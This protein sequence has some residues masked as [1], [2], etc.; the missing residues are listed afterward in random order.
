MRRLIALF[1]TT[2]CFLIAAQCTDNSG[3]SG[4]AGADSPVD[5]CDLDAY[6]G[7]GKACPL[8]SGRL[9]FQEC[10][11]GG[12]RCVASSSGPV[13]S[14]TFDNSCFPD[15]GPLDDCGGP[16]AGQLPDSSDAAL[17]DSSDSSALDASDGADGGG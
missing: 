17:V 4:D 8:V 2:A 15:C 9:C 5:I 7:N 16:D 13:W 3:N 12:C 11:A 6:T 14:C 10:E 1:A